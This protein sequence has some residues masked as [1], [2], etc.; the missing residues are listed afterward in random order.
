MMAKREGKHGTP[1][2]VGQQVFYTPGMNEPTVANAAGQPATVAAVDDNGYMTLSVF[3]ANGVVQQCSSVPMVDEGDELP[4]V[5][6][7]ATA[8]LK[9]IT[10]PAPVVPVLASIWPQQI[11]IDAEAADVELE[12]NGSGFASNSVMTC[13]GAN[14]ETRWYSDVQVTTIIKPSLGV[15]GSYPI[16]VKSGDQETAPQNLTFELP[17]EPKTKKVPEPEIHSSET[18]TTESKAELDK[19]KEAHK[20]HDPDEPDDPD[21]PEPHKRA[22]RHESTRR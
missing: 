12:C 14:V 21:K 4:A 2:A 17:A 8:T 19:M 1:A 9:D 15:P 7:Y 18:P 5:G 22:A 20:R 3:D 10:P 6:P 16:T 11:T 13:D